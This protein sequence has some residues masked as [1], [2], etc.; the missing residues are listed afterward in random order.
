MIAKFQF[1]NIF[2][3]LCSF[4]S[5]FIS[6]HSTYY[7][8]SSLNSILKWCSS[9]FY[10]TRNSCSTFYL[11]S[12]LY[13]FTT[14]PHRWQ[15]YPTLF[16]SFWKTNNSSNSGGWSWNNIPLIL[17]E[18][19]TVGKKKKVVFNVSRTPHFHPTT[20]HNLPHNWNIFDSGQPKL[21]A[22]INILG[23]YF[24]W[25]DQIISLLRGWGVLRGSRN[26]LTPLLLP[27][28]FKGCCSQLYGICLKPNY[29]SGVRSLHLINSIYLHYCYHKGQYSSKV[30]VALLFQRR[31]LG[32]HDPL[33]SLFFFFYLS[34]INILTPDQT[35]MI[36][37]LCN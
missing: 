25:Q 31:A 3:S 27:S 10:T 2:L 8:C 17:L 26:F 33:H 6:G 12:S 15:H 18:F 21:S 19:Q 23:S 37:L 13:I 5:D 22:V 7:S 11:W 9:R 29:N 34:P 16:L 1:F 14:C 28:F 4:F 30:L 24:S 32:R 36:N 20:W 35:D